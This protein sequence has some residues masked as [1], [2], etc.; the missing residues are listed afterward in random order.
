MCGSPSLHNGS[1]QQKC[2]NATVSYDNNRI[3]C[4]DGTIQ[5]STMCLR[6]RT[7]TNILMNPRQ[8]PNHWSTQLVR[9]PWRAERCVT[10]NLNSWSAPKRPLKTPPIGNSLK[11]T[12]KLSIYP[13]FNRCHLMII[14]TWDTDWRHLPPNSP[15]PRSKKWLENS[16]ATRV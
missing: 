12:V 8:P 13:P 16:S 11:I 1:D 14:I 2:N 6:R 3:I 15:P 10:R 4:S 7:N 9:Q 5:P